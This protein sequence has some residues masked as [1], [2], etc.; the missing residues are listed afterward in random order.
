MIYDAIFKAPERKAQAEARATWERQHF[1]G[2][3]LE[4]KYPSQSDT[5]H[6]LYF[7]GLNQKTCTAK[8]YPGYD[9]C[10]P[11]MYYV[12]GVVSAPPVAITPDEAPR[13]TKKH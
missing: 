1:S 10:P 3:R 13:K 12:N 5:E 2:W 9:P 7:D 11:Q 4:Q 6:G 8:A